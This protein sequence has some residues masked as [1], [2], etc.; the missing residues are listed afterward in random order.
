MIVAEYNSFYR[1]L[2]STE[3]L[4]PRKEWTDEHGC[5]P[6]CGHRGV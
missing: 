6:F 5:G 2:S 4:E 3:A 1:F